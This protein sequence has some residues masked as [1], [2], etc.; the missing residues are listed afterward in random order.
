MYVAVINP[1]KVRAGSMKEHDSRVINS[2]VVE[3][4][5]ELEG[6]GWFIYLNIVGNGRR[7]LEGGAGKKGFISVVIPVYNGAKFIEECVKSVWAQEPCGYEVE[8]I[9]VDDGSKDDSKKL[10]KALVAES[11]VPMQVLEHPGG[12]NKGVS[13]TRNL[14]VNNAAGEWICMLD[15][16]DAWEPCKL[17]E[18][19]DYIQANPGADILC[20]YGFNVDE[21]GRPCKGW[22]EGYIAG[23]YSGFLPPHD[24]KGPLYTF[25]QLLRGCPVLNSSVI[26]SRKALVETGGYK[27]G[28]SHQTEDW[29]VWT[30]VTTRHP[31]HLVAKPLV[32]YRIHPQSW[33]T[34]Y[35]SENLS[36]SVEFEF[37]IEL[38]YWMLSH[39]DEK[40]KNMGY[41]VYKRYFP[42]FVKPVASYFKK[43]QHPKSVIQR[44][45]W[46][47]W[48]LFVSRLPSPLAMRANS[49]II[50]SIRKLGMDTR[51]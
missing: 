25:D 12:V 28:L 26:V 14:A 4:L 40:I 43:V 45:L 44:L 38:L 51:F 2:D 32:K 35:R 21:E 8:I 41:S 11:P 31:I 47:T 20:T 15:A 9:A 48:H 37:F 34:R 29:L 36:G 6:R 7:R 3:C 18:Q 39:E 27:E 17:K 30:Q 10:L 24:F 16:D 50:K 46:F 1:F 42:F 23:D 49:F 5:K 19:V 33:T 22:T 13:A